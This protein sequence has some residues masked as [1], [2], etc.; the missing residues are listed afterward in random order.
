MYY[1]FRLSLPQ[2]LFFTT[3]KVS[4]K[5]SVKSFFFTKKMYVGVLKF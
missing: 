5:E 3:L 1:I 2:P 4:T